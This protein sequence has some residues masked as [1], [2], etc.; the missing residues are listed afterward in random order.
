MKPIKWGVWF[1][2]FG[3]C[4]SISLPSHAQVAGATLSGTISDAQGGV[5]P[6]ARVIAKDA[7]AGTNAET[8]ANGAGLYTLPNLR[9]GDYEVSASSTGFNTVVSKLTLTVGA[10]QELNFSLPVGQITQ[11]VTVTEAIPQIESASSTISGNVAG[12]EV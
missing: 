9:P 4:L 1:L 10:K 5:V 3:L 2:V 12:T 6:N 7:A 11:T 8:T